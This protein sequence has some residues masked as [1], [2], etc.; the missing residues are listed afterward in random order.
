MTK[1]VVFRHLFVQILCLSLLTNA[2]ECNQVNQTIIVKIG[3]SCLT[4]KSQKET[5]NPAVL[6]WFSRTMAEVR[7]SSRHRYVLVHGAGSFGHFTAK[8]Y[9][10]RSISAELSA[11]EYNP[12]NQRH[13]MEGV[14]ETRR[15][16][17]ALNQHVVKSLLSH[18]VPAVGLSPLTLGLVCPSTA[19]T[20]KEYQVALQRLV[21]LTLDAGLVPVLHGDACLYGPYGAAVLGGDTLMELLDADQ[22]IFLTDVSGIFTS[23]P[24]TDSDATLVELVEIDADGNLQT[25]GVAASE[26]RHKH[27]VTGGFAGKLT[28][29]T[30]IARRNVP[31]VI[32]ECGTRSAKQALQGVGVEVGTRVVRVDEK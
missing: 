28:A 23:N 6:D 13:T 8:E 17:Q 4:D 1:S 27:D 19:E 22:A 25:P 14:G 32:V 3:G 20:R 5:L 30:G 7:K 11:D 24:H 31:V 29:A 10:I 18:K 21:T 2:Q 12:E 26:S 9:G 15:S 16:V